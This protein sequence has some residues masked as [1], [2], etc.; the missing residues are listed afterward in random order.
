MGCLVAILVCCL[1]LFG[2]P[3][4]MLFIGAAAVLLELALYLAPIVFVIMLIAWIFDML[5]GN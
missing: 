4:I 2:I 5:T 1:I 3:L